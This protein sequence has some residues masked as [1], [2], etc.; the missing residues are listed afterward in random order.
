MN[1]SNINKL[2]GGRTPINIAIDRIARAIYFKV[3]EDDVVR[4]VR[5]ND[6][7]TVDYGKN[8]ELIG[9]EIIRVNKIEVLLKKAL[10]D[11]SAS[12]PRKTLQ[13]A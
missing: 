4:S 11:I 6:S 7:L 1:P 5:L 12:I 13:P 2:L 10:R 9:I 8:D 3:S